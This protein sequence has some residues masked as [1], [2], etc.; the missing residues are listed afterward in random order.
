MKQENAIRNNEM[1][2][3]K[4]KKMKHQH[5]HLPPKKTILRFFFKI[6]SSKSST[7]PSALLFLCFS[8]ERKGTLSF[9]F[10][11]GCYF[12]LE[13]FQEQNIYRVFVKLC[14]VNKISPNHQLLTR[15][16]LG[17]SLVNSMHV[18]FPLSRVIAC[19]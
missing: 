2:L 9:P 13:K 6:D 4:E 17:Q 16:K 1:H 5:Q 8:K 10:L 18:F 19:N 14:S 3:K 7:L 11:G 12:Y 15:A